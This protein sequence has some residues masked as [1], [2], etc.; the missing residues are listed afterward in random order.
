VIVVRQG[1]VGLEEIAAD[2]ATALQPGDV[3]K[4]IPLPPRRL[5]SEGSPRVQLRDVSRGN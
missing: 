5:T 4:V 2:D 1:A 3:L